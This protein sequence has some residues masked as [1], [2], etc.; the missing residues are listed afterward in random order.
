MLQPQNQ[1]QKYDHLFT[2]IDTGRLKIPV[3]QRDFVWTPLQTAKLVDS[4][5]KGFPIGTFIYWRTREELRH[6]RNIGNAQL[7][8]TPLGE[9]CSYVLDGQQRITSLYAVRKGIC[10]TREGQEVDFRAVS[11]NLA[12]DPDSDESLVTPGPPQDVPYIPVHR[13]LNGSIGEL[14]Q[15]Y[16]PHLAKVDLYRQRLTGY[17]FSTIVI[18]DYPIDIA[19]E[20][21]TRINTGG[22]ELT[23]FEI[24]A[25]KTFDQARGFDLAREYERL[26]DNNGSGKDLED[27]GFETVPASTVLQCV[28]SLV[29]RQVRARDILKLNKSKFIDTWPVMKDGL[30]TAV[31]YVRTHLRI[32]VSLM[33]PYYAVLVPFTYFFVRNSGD[34]PNAR[35]EKLLVQYF[36][37]ASLSNR[38][39][40]GVEGKLIQDLDRMDLILRNEAPSYQGEE[41]HL[42]MDDLRWRW[43]STSDGFCKAILCLYTYFEPK[44]FDHNSLVKVDN[45]WLKQANSKN[46][47]HFFPRAYLAKR[48]FADW[49]AN[50]ILNITLVD[51]YL[52]KRKIAAHAPSIYMKEFRRSNQ[53]LRETMKTHLIDDMEE[54]GV[55]ADD[56]V[57]FLELRGHTR[58]RRANQASGTRPE[59]ILPRSDR[60]PKAT[61]PRHP[62]EST[63][64]KDKRANIPTQELRDFVADDENQPPKTMLYPRDP[65]LDPQ[66]VWQGKDEQDRADLAVPVVP[67]YIQE[68][69]H[70][71]AIIENVRAQAR[72]EAPPDQ[73]ALFAD[74]N[75]ITFEDLVDFYHHEQNWSNRMILGDS[76][77]VMT[78][79]AE[80][81]GLKGKVQM[82]YMDPPYGIKFGSNWQVSTRKR[83]VKDG[84]AEDTTRQPEQVK[85]FRDTWQ[86]GIHSYLAYLRDRLVVARELLTDSGSVFVQIGDEN[87]HLVRCVLDEV[88]GSENFVALKSLSR[89]TSGSD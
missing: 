47:H 81:E 18:D 53:A 34:L 41:V 86:L 30:F 27:A 56:Y 42:T 5:I 76:L 54:Y 71:Q 46:Y 3:F 13:L 24:M 83:D 74:F 40:S 25:A 62:I 43:F 14:A 73:M 80:K 60:M 23:L 36:W 44:S 59:L 72:Q 70:P 4:I 58:S 52:N 38:F 63:R 33:L 64:H 89:K 2:G 9:L 77:L 28:A 65:S 19:C 67:I 79:L 50:C 66:L 15:D 12:L 68:K 48:S 39:N 45:S 88:F 35:Q 16:T 29:S 61:G 85:A 32:P 7:P 69:I 51:D 8:P 49:Q 11:I 26:I 1:S 31:D 87:V 37:W 17:D 6:S 75:N 20:I 82:I 57:G 78:S 10:F 84:K 55:W 22:T 21:F